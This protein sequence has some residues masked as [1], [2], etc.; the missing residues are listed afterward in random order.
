M[1]MLRVLSIVLAVVVSGCELVTDPNDDPRGTR[2]PSDDFSARLVQSGDAPLP[3]LLIRGGDGHVAVEGAFVTPVRCYTMEGW[4][5]VRGRTV[6]LT[7][8]AERKGG[9]CITVI[10]NFGYEATVRNLD[11]GTYTVRVTHALNGRRT[12]VAQEDVV[13]EQ[14]G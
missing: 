13:V 14:E 4:A 5:R 8:T 3:E 6:E 7:I 9:V 12:E 2:L 11:P 1:R 10:G